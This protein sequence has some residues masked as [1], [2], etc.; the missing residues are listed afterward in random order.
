M[1]HLDQK[2]AGE[3]ENGLAA[4]RLA[5]LAEASSD[6]IVNKLLDGTIVGW[7]AGAE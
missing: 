1:T 6:A 2:H 3:Q 5:A 4:A 7:N